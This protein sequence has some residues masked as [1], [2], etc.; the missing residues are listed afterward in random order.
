VKNNW[1]PFFFQSSPIPP[2][3]YP[4]NKK[5]EFEYEKH[6]GKKKLDDSLYIVRRLIML[7]V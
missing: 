4:K 2:K 7:L 6:K 5:F 1:V 3:L